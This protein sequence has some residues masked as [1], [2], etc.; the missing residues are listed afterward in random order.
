MW[1]GVEKKDRVPGAR[2]RKTQS[3][4]ENPM[5]RRLR[6]VEICR[7]LGAV[8]L[9]AVAGCQ[10]D[11]GDVRAEPEGSVERAA[12]ARGAPPGSVAPPGLSV[13]G[14]RP[15]TGVGVGDQGGDSVQTS[16]L[17]A[18]GEITDRGPPTGELRPAW[19]PAGTRIH[20]VAPQDIS[21]DMYQVD[22]AVVVVVDQPVTDT[23]G[24]VVLPSGAILIGRV[25]AA[26]SSGGSGEEAVLE[27]AFETLST[28]SYERP[29]EADVVEAVVRLDAQAEA[30]RRAAGARAAATTV[31]PGV[32]VAGQRFTVALRRGVA[33]PR[34]R[35]PSPDS[36]GIADTTGGARAGSP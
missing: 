24:A 17:P 10:G 20:V 18:Q 2:D 35:A 32:I 13:R 1:R 25:L 19:L 22:D 30:M 12:P 33:V 27:I 5:A 26:V 36:L 8:A 15:S 7:W 14:E 16:H 3:E 23:M 9:M 4:T 21:T 31:V 29:L 28:E 34:P 6:G 11:Q